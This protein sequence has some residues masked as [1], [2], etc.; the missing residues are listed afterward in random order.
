MKKILEKI[1]SSQAYT[2]LF[3]D[4]DVIQL[5]SPNRIINGWNKNV[6][7]RHFYHWALF[8]LIFAVSIFITT[9]CT[10]HSEN[11]E[12]PLIS[13]VQIETVSKK[14]VE[15]FYT[16]SATVKAKTNSVVA[17]MLTGKV[18]SIAVQ[19]GDYVE[20][21]QLLLTIDARDLSQK[22][23]GASAGIRAA[24]MAA[25]SAAQNAQ[26]A[27]RTYQRYK[28]LYDEKV[29]TKQEFD[30]YTT[31]KNVAALEYQRAQAGVQQAQAGLGEVKVFQSYARVTA[32]VSGIVTQR[33]IDLG[34]T[35]IQGQPIL[36]IE[37][38]DKG[39][40][41]SEIVANIDE[42][43]LDKVKEGEEVSLEVNGKTYKRKITKVVKYIDPTTRTFKAK[44]DITGLTGGQF[45]KI[46]IPV[47]KKDA[48][49]V[50]KSAIAQ[51]GE[52]TGVYTVDADN[53]VSYR[54]V[55]TGKEYGD[56]VEILSGL[57]D[58]D[59]IITVGTEKAIDGGK[60]DVK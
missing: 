9:G 28:N 21:G 26:M 41:K 20:K 53:V 40:L 23:S 44:V 35:A 52:L 24:Q 34:S 58:G 31:Q 4:I 22:A 12:H 49:T 8:I 38:E 17:S 39:G 1:K 47:S 18:T 60:I 54:I 5:Y 55:R 36:T 14:P 42:S 59:K 3:Q 27:D 32:P 7:K 16:T 25:S 15:S 19:E 13:D 6:G 45:A 11:L 10:K 29:I 56:R 37:A 51:K 43:Y 48:I 33:T 30:Q 46:N 2:Y 57:S 50:P